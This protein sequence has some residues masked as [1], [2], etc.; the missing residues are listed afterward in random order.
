VVVAAVVEETAV[1]MEE[2]VLDP[3]PPEET[4]AM[5]AVT[6]MGPLAGALAAAA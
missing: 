4:A 1:S 5:V 3:Q 2:T 6:P